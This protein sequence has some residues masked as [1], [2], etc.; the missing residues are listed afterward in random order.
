MRSQQLKER[1]KLQWNPLLVYKTKT[2]PYDGTEALT[3]AA[4]IYG[5]F[6]NK[7]MTVAHTNTYLPLLSCDEVAKQLYHEQKK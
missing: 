4:T 5:E 3:P 1:L 7:F 6:P 2:R